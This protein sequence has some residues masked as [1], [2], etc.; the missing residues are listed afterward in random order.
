MHQE[1]FNEMSNAFGHVRIYTVEGQLDVWYGDASV[2]YFDTHHLYL[3]IFSMLVVIPLTVPF[4]LILIFAKCLRK[5]SLSDKYLRPFI[6]AVHAPYKEKKGYWFI[7]RLLLVLLCYI[8]FAGERSDYL[9]YVTIGP[10]FLV[11]SLFQAYSRPYKVNFLNV[12]EI[13]IAF[14]VI[15]SYA[16]IIYHKFT[17]SDL[18]ASLVTCSVSV[19]FVFCIFVGVIIY[20][21]LCKFNFWIKIKSQ[22]FKRITSPLVPLNFEQPTHQ[23]YFSSQCD[24]KLYR[25]EMLNESLN[26]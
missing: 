17:V 9:L 10:I 3:V 16:M 26:S 11:F 1:L 13:F 24:C 23:S 18:N 7:F 8:L 6:E 21:V 22:L 4:M 2:G 12:L 15:F 19:I 5:Y 20:H 25:E 14:N